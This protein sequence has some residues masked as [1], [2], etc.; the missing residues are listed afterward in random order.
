MEDLKKISSFKK[1]NYLEL[2]LENYY[3]ASS[4]NSLIGST[5]GYIGY[6]SGGLLSEQIMKYPYSLIYIKN[7][8][9]AH[10]TIQNFIKKLLNTNLF[11]DNK[12][13]KIYINN[14][15]IVIDN[16]NLVKKKIGIIETK[17]DNLK[18]NNYDIT[19]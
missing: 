13:R 12:G 8:N 9:K 11:I 4:L 6:E 18:K 16:P 3:D 15:I 2:D 1:E 5:K 14:T 17:D 10:F 7:L 19:L